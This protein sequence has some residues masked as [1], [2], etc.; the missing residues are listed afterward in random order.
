M[1]SAFTPAHLT[2]VNGWVR[3]RPD[4][5]IWI[6]CPVRFPEDPDLGRD[7]W[8]E[9]MAQAWWRQSGRRYA[10]DK[11]GKL[12]RMLEIIHE[13]GSSDV[14]CHQ[15]WACYLDTRV[16]PLPLYLGIWATRGDREQQLR[17]LSGATDPDVLRPPAVTEF[18]TRALGTG[19]VA[20]RHKDAGHGMA[21]EILGFAFR[22]KEFE[23]DVQ[24]TVSTPD[25]RQLHRA[26][27]FIEDFI[28]GITVYDNPEPLSR[29]RGCG[30][31]AIR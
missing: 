13:Q 18:T 5:R 3:A 22:S 27:P 14:P 20:R 1:K 12:A 19:I 24:V 29:R 2:S 28:R 23:T 26:T 31:A 10:R 30:L 6:P 7:Y 17:T 9:T 15:I 4:F 16:P 11:V 21:V 25:V 8:A